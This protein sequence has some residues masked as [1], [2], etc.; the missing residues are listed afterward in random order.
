MSKLTWLHVSDWHQ[1]G[2]EFDRKVVCDALMDDIKNRKDRISADVDKIDFIIFSGD[3]AYNGKEEEYKKANECFIKPLLN[4]TGVSPKNLFVVPGNHDLDLNT[5]KYLPEELKKPFDSREIVNEWLE[6][7]KPRNCLLGP[8]TDFGNFVAD[9]EGNEFNFV[10]IYPTQE[11]SSKKVAILGF[12]SALM[13]GRNK[14][15]KSEIDDYGKLA[16]GELQI[17]DNIRYTKAQNADFIIAVFHHPFGWLA[18]CDH[19]NVVSSIKQDTHF[20]LC[21][22]QHNQ[23]VEIVNGTDGN[24]VI[25]PAGASYDRRDRPYTNAYN[26]VHIDFTSNKGIVYLRCWSDKNKEWKDDS[27]SSKEGKCNFEI[28]DKSKKKESLQLTDKLASNALKSSIQYTPDN[29]VFNVPYRAKEEGVIGRSDDLAKVRNQLLQGRKTA[30]GHTA[31]FH[32]IGGLGKTQLAVEYA[33]KFRESYPFGVIWL[34]ADQDIDVQLIKIAVDAK[35]IAPDTK[36]E[37]IL[38][39]AKQRLT[40]Y[41]ECLIIFDNVENQ[42]AIKHYLPIPTA[43]PHILLTS[44]TAQPGFEPIELNFL[45]EEL[46][47]DLLMKESGREGNVLSEEEKSYA[48]K[49]V[50]KLGGL[51][52]A[53]EIAG[54]Y[55]RYYS[56]CTFNQYYTLLEKNIK[57]AL[58]GKMMSSFT[59]HEQDLYH[60]LQISE[61]LFENS[62]LLRDVLNLLAWSGTGF[63]GLSLMTSAM[64]IAEDDLSEAVH[65]GVALRLINRATDS[66]NRYEIHRLLHHVWQEQEPLTIEKREWVDAICSGLGAWFK[67]YR[68][69]FSK[70]KDY[71]LEINHLESWFE[72]AKKIKSPHIAFLKWLQ[73]Y[74]PYH[75]GDY[76]TSHE[77]IK[78]SLNILHDNSETVDESL[79]ANIYSDLG[80]TFSVLGKYNDAL[81]WHDKS[82]EL[83]KKLYGYDNEDTATSLD[84]IGAT[85]GLLSEYKLAIKFLNEALEIRKKLFGEMHKDT[86]RSFNNIGGIY[87]FL[88][89]YE[90]ALKFEEKA[91]EIRKQLHGEEHPATASSLND[92]GIAYGNLENY[93]KE[94]EYKNKALYILENLY[95]EIHPDTAAIMGSVGT[96]YCDLG[97]YKKAFEYQNKAFDIAIK[98]YGE[99]HPATGASL[100]N[101]GATYSHSGNNK[102]ALEYYERALKIA[103]KLYDKMHHNIATALSNIGLA[104]GSMK[105]HFL[106][107][108]YIQDALDIRISLFG[109]RHPDTIFTIRNIVSIY[110]EAKKFIIARNKV[111]EYFKD[112]PSDSEVF[113][114]KQKLEDKINKEATKSGFRP[115]SSSRSKHKKKKKK[116]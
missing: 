62:P 80:D 13:S 103:E 7:G 49:I 105:N 8:F 116:R 27:E 23:K 46:S 53:I 109:K 89:D 72:N 74:P 61:S 98:L 91:L 17:Y 29:S 110:C 67:E 108:K 25:I 5:F 38:A 95:G 113:G 43:N 85:Y 92:V 12:N 78:E 15:E 86:A 112:V 88:G 69:D 22:H 82:L 81:L 97:N 99:I 31:L 26:L 40:T 63:M 111:L 58:A 45:S 87:G 106:A 65:L 114:M 44:R 59:K 115:I 52:L 28:P 64:N 19:K 2:N 55:L 6:E 77:I 14:N 96:A 16:I 18:E 101:L 56:T 66:E 24:Y 34:S 47:F 42:E 83:R 71:E 35:W 36:H 33:Y 10:K 54:A 93:E 102:K 60:T 57:N 51:P 41:S 90:N 48:N 9:Y 76:M 4:A 50:E 3:I 73:A 30:I 84:N 11:P 68:E 75:R 37:D 70:L 1:K 107:I 100:N 94:F 104:Y 32:G 20:I 79:E 21:G 39:I